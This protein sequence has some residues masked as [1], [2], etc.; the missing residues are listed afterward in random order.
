MDISKEMVPSD[1][2][3]TPD[4]K[5]I[6]IDRADRIE[7]EPI[8]KIVEEVWKKPKPIVNPK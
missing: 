6:E 4:V 1:S 2:R 8:A 5:Y 7:M 3:R